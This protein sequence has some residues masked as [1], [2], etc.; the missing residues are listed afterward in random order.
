MIEIKA[1]PELDRAVAEAIGG[2]PH[3]EGVMGPALPV[4]FCP[5]TDLNAAVAAAQQVSDHFLLS[6]NR[7]TGDKWEA[8]VKNVP[9]RKWI[10]GETACLAICQ[11]ILESKG[12]YDDG[13][14]ER[15]DARGR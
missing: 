9:P 4:P 6:R 13:R 15:M 7:V 11:A 8:S 12:A 14:T 5:S 3:P 10:L 1:G 2:T